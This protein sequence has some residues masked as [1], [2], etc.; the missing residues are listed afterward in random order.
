M[1]ALKYLALYALTF[2]VFIVVDLTWL[3]LVAQGFYRQN[4]GKLMLEQPIWPVAIAFYLLYV[5]GV[6]VLV[7]L[8]AAHA[9]SVWQAVLTGAL[10]GLVAY[11]TYDLTNW[12]TLADWPAVVSVADL[13]WGTTLTAIVSTAGYYIA[14]WLGA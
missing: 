9:G 2:L 13:A 11:G 7:V 5:V 14:R 3:G 8:P 10:L 6:L 4:L 1:P 12:S